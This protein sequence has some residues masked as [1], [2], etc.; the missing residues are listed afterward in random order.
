MR[1]PCTAIAMTLALASGASAQAPAQVPVQ[2]YLTAADG[3][4]TAGERTMTFALHTTQVG[5]TASYTETQMVMVEAGYFAAYIGD[6]TALP[7]SLFRDE[8]TLYLQVT[9]DGEPL[10]PR[11]Q[12][13]TVPYA[14]YAEH[15]RWSGIQN[16]P[17]S[18][19]D[20]DNDTTYTAGTGLSLAGTTFAVDGS[21][22]QSRVTGTCPAGQAIRAIDDTGA[23]TCQPTAG[24][25]GD[26]TGVNPGV[27]LSGGGDSGTV[28]LS[29]DTAFLQ[30]RVS[31][32]CG[33]GEAI[34][35]ISETGGVSCEPVGV[36]SVTAGSGLVGG[37]SGAV[38]LSANT[39]VLQ[40]RVT[41]ACGASQAIRSIDAAG[42]VTCEPV[43]GGGGS[44][45]LDCAT[46][47][48]TQSHTGAF[49]MSATCA[50][51]YEISGGGHNWFNGVTDVWFWQSSPT[52]ET[53]YTCRGNVNRAGASSDITCYARCCRVM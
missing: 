3:T 27:G 52:S 39:S 8:G 11:F 50:A 34:R 25:G 51:G 43:G 32:S 1:L 40:A 44:G 15:T 16:V 2:G 13:A 45:T 35:S 20:G 30:R 17:A 49:S 41:G 53:T 46:V 21:R 18:L 47:S 14:A 10:T 22:V 4:P 36:T 24:G 5:G 28:T 31:S 19:A 9:V 33:P 23:V 29:A 12:L 37:G 38:S 6:A 26:I 48:T 7:L 42:G